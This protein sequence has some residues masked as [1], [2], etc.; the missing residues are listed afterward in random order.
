MN[1]PITLPGGWGTGKD[2]IQGLSTH[3]YDYNFAP[4]EIL[5]VID[6][7]QAKL[8]AAGIP[9]M[10][11]WGTETGGEVTGRFRAFDPRAPINIQRW[12]LLAAAKGTESLILYGHVAET[13][14]T[15]LLSNPVENPAVIQTLQ[16]SYEIGGRRICNAAVLND[17]RVWVTTAN[18]RTWLK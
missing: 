12:V 9:D 18:G 1:A 17:G 2:H 6:G 15:A 4:V 7:Y 5:D 3:Y 8:D 10:P 13:D 11:I 14:L 16:E